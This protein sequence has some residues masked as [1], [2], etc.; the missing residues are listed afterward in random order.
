MRR[1]IKFQSNILKETINRQSPRSLR[2]MADRNS[3]D[4]HSA[5]LPRVRSDDNV[6]A[7]Q[8]SGPGIAEPILDSV[9]DDTDQKLQLQKTQSM[10]VW[11]PSVV[12]TTISENAEEQAFQKIEDI[13]LDELRNDVDKA[14]TPPRESLS[15]MTSCSFLA[16]LFLV[17]VAIAIRNLG[18]QAIVDEHRV[19]GCWSSFP[20]RVSRIF[21]RIVL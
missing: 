2:A 5:S 17:V 3:S 12:A 8:L 15:G 16:H 4:A 10:P 6:K 13:S 21:L 19:T 11:M 7:C 18:A 14:Y 20:P 1:C 9:I